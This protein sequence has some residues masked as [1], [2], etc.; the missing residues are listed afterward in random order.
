MT[1][2][3]EQSLGLGTRL[4]NVG[5][6]T[7]ELHQLFF[8]RRERMVGEHDATDRLDDRDLGQVRRTAP[9][10]DRKAQSLTHAHVVERLALMVRRHD[11]DAVPVA[12]LNRDVLAEGGNEIVTALRWEAAELDGCLI[13]A[14][15]LDAQRLGLREDRLETVE[16]GLA[17][18]VVVRIPLAGDAGAG[19]TDVEY[20]RAGAHHILLIP[21]W[22]SVE[23]GFRVDPAERRS[24]RGDE[25][26]RR[27]LQLEDDRLVIGSRDA[28]D[29]TEFGLASA[30]NALRRV[31][32]P[33]IGGEHVLRRQS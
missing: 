12:L 1:R 28:L 2:F 4:L 29:H 6:V 8:R 5:A 16:V 10:I 31:D 18:V 14:N 24:Q 32:N 27:I 26:A 23:L 11:E 30:R 17:L 3:L 20:E 21:T 13:T 25:S 22:I 33:L 9:T 15:G 19:L 7:G